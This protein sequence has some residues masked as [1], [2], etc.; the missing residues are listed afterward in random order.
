MN[1]SKEEKIVAGAVPL[2]P[3]RDADGVVIRFGDTL[4]D[5]RPG[6]KAPFEVYGIEY[7]ADGRTG[8]RTRKKVCHNPKSCHHV[9]SP[10]EIDMDEVTPGNTEKVYTDQPIPERDE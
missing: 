5:E 6:F 9:D 3:P 1:T 2:E 4:V 10:V 8:V 7:R